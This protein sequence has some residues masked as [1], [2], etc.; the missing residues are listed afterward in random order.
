MIKNLKKR[1][2]ELLTAWR[3][4][5]LPIRRHKS[6]INDIFLPPKFDELNLQNKSYV[7][8]A[9]HSALQNAATDEK[10]TK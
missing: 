5:A 10:R 4:Q 1:R 8:D 3:D 7:E 9:M 2:S 6:P